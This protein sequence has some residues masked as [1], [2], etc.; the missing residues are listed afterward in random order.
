LLYNVGAT[1][2]AKALFITFGM[3]NIYFAIALMIRDGQ[4]IDRNFLVS[5]MEITRIIA[6]G[7]LG[8]LS[9]SFVVF[10]VCLVLL[11][12][13]QKKTFLGRSIN[14]TGGNLTAAKLGGLPTR[15]VMILVYA[16]CGL[17]AAVSAIVLFSRVPVTT[18]TVGV[19]FERD[20]I[21]AV[22]IGGTSL[23]GGKGGVMRTLMG[24]MLIVLMSNCMNLLMVG[25]H[26][27]E[28]LRG[29]IFVTAIVLDL[30]SQGLSIIASIKSAFSGGPLVKRPPKKQSRL[31]G[32]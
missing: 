16:I 11:V 22:V 4:P 5:D 29:A 24:V 6:Q 25:T 7:M 32:V 21:M 23:L 8:P 17:M 13:F 3:A 1:T 14:Y 10:V 20:A 12:F 19:N 26:M 31:E 18:P 15:N 30:R 28:V 2:Q 9:V 27:Q